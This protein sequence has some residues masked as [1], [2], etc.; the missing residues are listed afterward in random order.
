MK[1]RRLARHIRPL[2]FA[3]LILSVLQGTSVA[4][5]FRDWDNPSASGKGSYRDV[6][7]ERPVYPAAAQAGQAIAP[8]G[9]IPGVQAGPTAE[10][11]PDGQDEKQ[12]AKSN[13][14]KTLAKSKTSPEDAGVVGQP[15]AA[16]A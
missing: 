14:K 13:G 8:A 12:S 6:S 5:P 15:L 7:T 16:P 3:L 9:A 10:Q 2:Y 4:W 11:S 1:L